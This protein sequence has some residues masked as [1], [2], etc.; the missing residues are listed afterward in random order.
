MNHNEFQCAMCREVFEKGW[1]DEEAEAE[2]VA[3][4]GNIPK[5]EC[6]TVCDDCFRTLPIGRQ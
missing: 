5:E 6:G 2:L 1:T 4:W 3:L